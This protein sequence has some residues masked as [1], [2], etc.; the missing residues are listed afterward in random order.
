ML[1]KLDRNEKAGLLA[2]FV[3]VIGVSVAAGFY[4]ADYIGTPTGQ[5][6]SEASGTEIKQ[7]VQ[8][9]MEAQLASQEQQLMMMAQQNENISEDDLSISANVGE[10]SESE[11]S[12]L[13][14]VPVEVSGTVPAQD[15]SGEVEDMDE[16][17]ILYVSSDGEYLFQEPTEIE[18]TISQIEEQA[19]QMQQQ[20]EQEM[21]EEPV[22]P[23]EPQTE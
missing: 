16:E 7:E 17:N 19:Q 3:V 21:P 1:G 20:E 14:E 4:G 6:G 2:A 23:E 9:I 15:D 10:P 18:E 5:V 11:I 8:T 12:G 22:Q 13:L